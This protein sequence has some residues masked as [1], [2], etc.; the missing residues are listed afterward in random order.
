MDR[1]AVSVVIPAYNAS[2]TLERAIDSVLG[3][4]RAAAQIVVVDDGSGEDLSS[5][6]E[7][8]GGRIEWIRQSNAGA[9]AAR[10]RGIEAARGEL[11]AFLDAD[12]YWEPE[13][14]ARQ[15][16]P[17]RAHPR[18]GLCSSRY[19]EQIPGS[20]RQLASGSI[21]NQPRL[22]E[23]VRHVG[24]DAFEAA[25]CVWTG[26][27]VVRRKL[28]RSLRFRSG[29]EPAEDRDLWIRLVQA[30]PSIHLGEPLAT[31]VLEPDSLSRTRI[32][33]DCG[34]MLRIVGQSRRLL[35]GSGTRY[36]RQRILRRWAAEYLGMGE[37]GSALRP[38]L[39]RLGLAP[40][41]PEAWWIASKCVLL[42]SGRH[43]RTPIR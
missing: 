36:W 41:S 33:R 28:L 15:V 7:R 14:L 29:L 16:R 20:E 23:V 19:Y 40:W 25:C 27:V 8:Y 22:D 12:D 17:F 26:T 32:D 21:R 2:A 24:R 31:A 5:I 13:K 4:S 37:P 39:R 38:A 42:S 9:A 6:R 30:A 10:N 35:G 43:F 18:L 1:H 34:N 11:V 3:Q